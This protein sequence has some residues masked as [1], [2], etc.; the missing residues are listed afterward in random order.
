MQIEDYRTLILFST[1]LGIV[2]IIWI[3]INMKYLNNWIDKVENRFEILG[4]LSE[5]QTAYNKMITDSVIEI[6]KE[7]RATK[8]KVGDLTQ[9]ADKNEFGKFS[10]NPSNLIQ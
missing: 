1:F 7:T 4:K 8:E 3:V 10:E 6:E 9:R 2:N 5:T